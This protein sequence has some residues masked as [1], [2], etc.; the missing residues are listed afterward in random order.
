[1]SKIQSNPI[2]VVIEDVEN[3]TD[4]N[5]ALR[6]WLLGHDV[7]AVA[8][9]PM[10]HTGRMFGLIDI[11]STTGSLDL[12]THALQIF[13]SI[14]DQVGGLV[15][16]HHLTEESTYASEI[17]ERQAKTFSE[18]ADGQ[19]L[20]QMASI[21]ARHMLP[22]PGRFISL[23]RFMYDA[24]GKITSWKVLATANRERTY[25]WDHET[26][27]WESL[28][29]EVQQAFLEGQPY[30]VDDTS[31]LAPSDVGPGFYAMLASNG[32][33]SFISVPMLIDGKPVATLGVASRMLQPFTK[34]EITAFSNLADQVG[35]LIYT[36]TLLDDAHAAHEVANNLVLATRMIMAA[37]RHDD[38]AQAVIYTLARNMT[39]VSISLFDDPHKTQIITAIGTADG[40]LSVAEGE[41]R[42]SAPSDDDIEMLR[43]G[44]P[45][46]I[47]DIQ[48]EGSSL[49]DKTQTQYGRLNIHWSASF[50]LRV[51]DQLLGTLNILNTQ[52][53]SLTPEEADAYSAICD[54]IGIA[55]QNHNLLMSSQ[56]TLDF[57]QQ[58]FD[59][60]NKIY[61]AKSNPEILQAIYEFAGTS[62][63]QAQLGLVEIDSLPPT[64]HV[65]GEINQGQTS[66]TDHSVELGE[67]P[68]WETLSALETL[69]A[70]NVDTEEF[71]TE[72][73]RKQLHE[74]GVKG[75][76]IVPLVSNHRLIGLI[77]F[78]NQTP[79]SL[80]NSR[81]RALRILADQAAVVFEN[82]S[83]LKSTAESLEETQI[84]Y[85]VNRSI[86]AAQDTLDIL[87][88]LRVH[89]A[90]EAATINLMT[91]QYD[92]ATQSMTNVTIGYINTP[93]DEQIGDFGV[94]DL[95]GADRLKMVA[96]YWN[97]PDSSVV[98]VEET[99]T[100]DPEHP[101]AEFYRQMNIR[102]SVAIPIRE[103]NQIREVVNLNF[104]YPQTFTSQQRRLYDALSDQI[105]I[106]LQSHR[107]LR[108]V[109]VN[110]SQLGSQVR[111]LQIVNQLAMMLGSTQDES[112][113]LDRATRALTEATGVDH[114]SIILYNT[115]ENTG[116]VVSEYPWQGAIQT[117][118]NTVSD[119]LFEPL[120]KAQEL[121]II[122]DVPNDGRLV[123]PLKEKVREMG[124][125]TMAL[126]PLIVSDRILGGVSLEIFNPIHKFT[127]QIVN[128]AQTI[129]AEL[130]IGIQNLRLLTDAQRRA[131]QLQRIAAF[132]ESVQATL[133]M[134]TIFNIMM[135]E[136]SQMLPHNQLSIALYDPASGQLRVV[137]QRSEEYTNVSL[138]NGEVLPI[139]GPVEKVWDSWEMVHIPDTRNVPDKV[140]SRITTRSL[141]ISPLISRGRI[142]GI[143]SV[144]NLRPYMYSDTDV[145]VFQQM[146]NQLAIAIENTE[147]FT[148]SQR[149]AKNEA[150]VNDISSQLQ[151]QLDIHSM[152]DVTVNELGKVLGARKARI[153]MG[154]TV[155]NPNDE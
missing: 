80:P 146:V 125:Q 70:P 56:E 95:I 76:V 141:I 140:S 119:P 90:P 33:K 9:L 100:L 151:R 115:L 154:T 25:S 12:P 31:A 14:A 121:I 68:A 52:P 134:A 45:V 101:L 109:Q 147:A 60:T 122:E 120:Q 2:P 77:T 114:S 43:R 153:R 36:R 17:N 137:A 1:M 58:Q 51:G 132:N 73:E 148:Q 94:G 54:Q 19:D 102:S 32:V 135:N 67:Y 106:V 79:Q 107:L 75:L 61:N 47:S 131:D 41:L 27:D 18:L 112:E 116:T 113:L 69:H 39:A 152:L 64:V 127:P 138:S 118:I 50:G 63:D 72:V 62:Y 78:T 149:V 6:T 35:V 130:S 91:V 66:A 23:S 46:Y 111:V 150:L 21:V 86:L 44:L 126:F 96:D 139:A 123:S 103:N 15:Q 38:M 28:S 13:Q 16:V 99:E 93:T 34:T 110:A 57:V 24:A 65:V 7:K 105:S 142:L 144:G 124:V 143:V 145:V 53:V 92:A 5:D 8:M 49:S 88:T 74:Q 89:I 133:D 59:A 82:Q 55:L 71:L 4:I 22:T 3:E 29:P 48:A 40:P 84:L 30:V 42:D 81:L 98:L 129:I 11:N 83:L 117:Q 85:E 37:D 26:T 87:R 97:T 108:D 10:Y 104:D 20:T 128:I 155:P 136:S